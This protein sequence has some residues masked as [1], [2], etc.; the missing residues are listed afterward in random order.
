M[1]SL[2]CEVARER[3]PLFVGGD[4]DEASAKAVRAHLIACVACRNEA[5]ALQR[6]TT[7]LRGSAAAQVPGVDDGFFAAMH[8]S[9]LERVT[10]AESE[11]PVGNARGLS[12]VR[13]ASLA[14]AGA[15]LLA[16]GCWW[17]MGAAGD[18]VWKRRPTAT[19]AAFEEPKAVPYAGPRAP[20]RLLGQDASDD[21]GIEDAETQGLRARDQLRSL[22]DDHGWSAPRPKRPR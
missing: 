14:L 19:P 8:A 11:V 13:V 5:S 3:L 16:L 21:S 9:I 18:S 4:V 1:I 22:V 6:A 15:A 20:M 10:Q 2:S 7:S 12:V 17:G